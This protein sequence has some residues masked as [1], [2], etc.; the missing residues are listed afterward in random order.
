MRMMDGP[1][2]Q[3]TWVAAG[4]TPIS[5]L[6]FCL[7]FCRS[8]VGMTKIF[9]RQGLL[10]AGTWVSLRQTISKLVEVIP[11][12]SFCTFQSSGSPHGL[13]L[14]AVISGFG[15]SPN[16]PGLHVIFTCLGHQGRRLVDVDLHFIIPKLCQVT[17]QSFSTVLCL[18]WASRPFL[19][20]LTTLHHWLPGITSE[21]QLRCG[22]KL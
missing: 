21:F 19:E 12:L 11:P 16:N 13:M 2:T 1:S 3:D 9:G 6:S 20:T 10:R 22:K 14:S 18:A 4:W 17:W 15:P 7:S 5:C 8:H